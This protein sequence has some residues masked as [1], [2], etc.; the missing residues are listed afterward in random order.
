MEEIQ[1]S[2]SDSCPAYLNT[3]TKSC[4]VT[5]KQKLQ[6]EFFETTIPPF[7]QAKTEKNNFLFNYP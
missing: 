4:L 2:F 5:E 1:K 6:F 7:L 3:P